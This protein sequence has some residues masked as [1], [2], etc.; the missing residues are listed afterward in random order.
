MAI[1]AQ[2]EYKKTIFKEK[3]VSKYKELNEGLTVNTYTYM[4]IFAAKRNS[5]YEFVKLHKLLK[6]IVY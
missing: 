2:I 5:K 6:K 3:R 4:H 1:H